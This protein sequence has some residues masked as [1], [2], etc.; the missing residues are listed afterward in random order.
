[1]L[2][3]C[4]TE[5]SFRGGRRSNRQSA[6][7]ALGIALSAILNSGT[8]HEALSH[9]LQSRPDRDALELTGQLAA[10]IYGTEGIPDQYTSTR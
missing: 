1:M 6:G 3:Q 5:E 7:Y 8:F 4:L 10:M 2:G 9:A